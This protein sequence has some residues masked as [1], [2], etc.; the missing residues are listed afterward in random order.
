MLLAHTGHRVSPS[1]DLS[2]AS[3]D[4]DASL[5]ACRL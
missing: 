4:G 2:R 5:S 3:S 1:N